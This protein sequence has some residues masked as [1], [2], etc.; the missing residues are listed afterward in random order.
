MLSLSENANNE[1]CQK[2]GE[3]KEKKL[4][5]L[6]TKTKIETV[7][8]ITATLQLGTKMI[9]VVKMKIKTK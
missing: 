5:N 8:E 1:I 2:S 4:G 9:N 6:L 7:T 3:N